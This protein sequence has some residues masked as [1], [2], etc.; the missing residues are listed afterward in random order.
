MLRHAL[1]ILALSTAAHAQ[2]IDAP[3][4]GDASSPTARVAREF[5]DAFCVGEIATLERLYAPDVTFHDEIFTFANRAD[6]IGMWR[7]LLTQGGRFSYE[8]L[9]VE[10][11]VATVRWLA[12]YRLFGRPIHNVITARLTIR[13]GRIV[14]HLDSFSW[15]KWSRQA[16][17]LGPIPTWGP[18]E[19]AIK[20]V[21]RA[22]LARQAR[23]AAPPPATP[24]RAGIIDAL[25]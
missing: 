16:F 23:A 5:Y 19:R 4:G 10:G 20:H 21:M 25:R 6:T 13:D 11:E 3:L 12:D 7:V 15:A 14:D 22:T 8:L 9:G 17:P 18:I 1:L 24:E 2:A